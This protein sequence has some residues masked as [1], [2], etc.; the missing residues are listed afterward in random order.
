MA[1]EKGHGHYLLKMLALSNKLQNQQDA[2]CQKAMYMVTEGASLEELEAAIAPGLPV[3]VNMAAVKRLERIG[4]M[5]A[6]TILSAEEESRYR[7]WPTLARMGPKIVRRGGNPEP[8]VSCLFL[9][10]KNFYADHEKA[11]MIAD[12]IVSCHRCEPEKVSAI[13]ESEM[14][15]VYDEAGDNNPALSIQVH[16]GRLPLVMNAIRPK[17]SID[18]LLKMG[19]RII[20][21]FGKTRIADQCRELLD[22]IVRTL[23]DIDRSN[24]LDALLH[25]SEL[26]TDSHE[27]RRRIWEK[28]FPLVTAKGTKIQQ[29]VAW[30]QVAAML[31]VERPSDIRQDAMAASRFFGSLGIDTLMERLRLDNDGKVRSAAAQALQEVAHDDQDG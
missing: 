11:A 8:I 17:D 29:G 10:L 22:D 15:K 4:S 26:A 19:R 1:V 30:N 12:A 25:L 24:A 28:V 14:D 31:D 20:K 18:L 5:A 3:L 23:G 6:F 27:Y 16:L 2:N 21:T 9:G 7:S 13:L